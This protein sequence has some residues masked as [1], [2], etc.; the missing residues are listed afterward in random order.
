[1]TSYR[2]FL[3]GRPSAEKELKAY[4]DLLGPEWH[5]K[6]F[7]LAAKDPDYGVREA[8][9]ALANSDGGEVFLGVNDSRVVVGTSATEGS[10]TQT[11]RQN[12]ARREEWCETCLTN[13]V[14]DVLAIP[15]DG[16]RGRVLV[17]EVFPPGVPV[18]VQTDDDRD[19]LLYCYR[20]G[21]ST[22][23]AGTFT[24]IRRYRE[25]RAAQILRTLYSELSRASQRIRRNASLPPLLDPPLPYYA[26]V[27]SDGSLYRYLPQDDLDFIMGGP[28]GGAGY[29]D[30]YL[31]FVAVVQR[32]RAKSGIPWE[33]VTVEILAQNQANSLG[34]YPT[35]ISTAVKQLQSHLKLRGILVE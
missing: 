13:V 30:A 19:G 17:L 8:V 4:L 27:L 25:T 15:L 14:R 3:N 1:M 22:H 23:R 5:K 16:E 20:D 28:N 35:E 2:E 29:A 9:T 7:K 24:A 34:D 26:R 18:F 6:E 12:T 33:N 21:G 10:L 32:F 11:L 31:R